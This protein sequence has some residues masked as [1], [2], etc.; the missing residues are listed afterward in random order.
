MVQLALAR[1]GAIL[2]LLLVM[3]TCASAGDTLAEAYIEAGQKAL[4]EKNVS[5]ADRL[6]ALAIREASES[7]AD[8]VLP[9]ALLG[10]A[11]AK[12][13]LGKVDEAGNLFRLCVRFADTLDDRDPS[14]SIAALAGLA[15]VKAEQGGFIE[16][17][18]LGHK[19]ANLLVAANLDGEQLMALVLNNL[20][21]T[22][23]ALGKHDDAKALALKAAEVLDA[24]AD[25]QHPHHFEVLDTLA[26]VHHAAGDDETADTL[27]LKSHELAKRHHGD[28][29]SAVAGSLVTLGRIR[30]ARGKHA[31][32]EQAMRSAIEIY[33]RNVPAEH[34]SHRRARDTFQSLLG[35]RSQNDSVPPGGEQ[36]LPGTADLGQRQSN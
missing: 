27:A 29:S 22:K 19:A 7:A 35:A 6:F 24:L 36:L 30:S 3:H 23:S 15:L 33:G 21:M 16:S 5:A 11:E 1:L 12:Y 18:A 2:S 31:D 20:A 10:A 8:D 28:D 9:E 17:E 14:F 4:M 32:A 26:Q 13:S 25:G 34:P